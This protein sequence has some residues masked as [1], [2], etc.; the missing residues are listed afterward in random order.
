[1]TEPTIEQP[2]KLS[3][4][5]PNVFWCANGAELCERA[6]YYGMFITLYRYLNMDVGF[7]DVETGIVTGGFA[8]GIYFFPT[9]MGIMADKIGFKRALVL[10][11]ALLTVG[12]ALLGAFQLKTTAVLSLTLIMFGGAIIKPVISG[13]VAKCSDSAHRARAM[14]IFYMVV[15]I[16]SFSGKGLAG[17]LNEAMG[18]Q[19]INFYAAGMSFLALILIS[20]FYRNIDTEGV[21]KTVKEALRGLLTVLGNIRFLCLI[22]IIAGFWLIQGQLYG[23]MPTYVERMLGSG[24]KPEWLANINPFVVV[25]FVVPITHL[26]RHFKPAN[27]IGI[28]LMI[29]PFTALIIACAPLLQKYT[30]Q[31]IDIGALS[32]HPM[33]LAIVIGIALQGLA[34]CFLSPKWLEF[35]SKQAPK[36]EVGLYLGYSHLTTFIAWLVGFVAAGFLLNTYC[37]DPRK[38]DDADRHQWRQ[39]I[40]QNYQFTLSP[41]SGEFLGDGGAISPAILR[42]FEDHDLSIPSNAVLAET[43][44]RNGWKRDPERRWNIEEQIITIV[45]VGDE[46]APL[47]AYASDADEPGD[48]TRTGAIDLSGE[49]ADEFDDGEAVSEGV[50]VALRQ[51]GLE[52]PD[53]AILRE[54]YSKEERPE[55]VW[56]IVVKHFAIEEAKLE[57]DADAEKAGRERA[58]R[59]VLVNSTAERVDARELVLP[60]QYDRAHYVWYA[61]AGVGFTAFCAMLIFIA[62]TNATDKRRAAEA[63]AGGEA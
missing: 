6:A 28:G 29:I 44:P 26:I 41:D 38:L 16:G 22:F 24:Y 46:N 53:D 23:A 4:R 10:A 18:L 47:K 19:Y 2:Q 15:N 55:Q 20:A 25:L 33:I 11:F 1:M 7:T 48:S 17:Y 45:Q 14:S 12:Y 5:F 63:A 21:G 58:L 8:G 62:I 50:A 27:A 35:A 42:E 43:Q 34:E 57:T 40:Y 61:F 54:E 52:W 9:F 31:S 56:K 32:V 49:L 36:G 3:W 37:P 60:S 59:D 30:G 13:T 51:A 39:A